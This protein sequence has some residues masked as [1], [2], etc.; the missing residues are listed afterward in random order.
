VWFNP[1]K[2]LTRAGRSGNVNPAGSCVE[3]VRRGAVERDRGIG[4]VSPHK[5]DHPLEQL[6][7]VFVPYAAADDDALPW[8]GTQ[9][10]GDDRLHVVASVEAEEASL[11]AEA[12]L[13]ESSYSHL[14]R[15]GYRLGVPGPG[16]PIRI[17]PD[18]ENSRCQ[19]CR[20][21]LRDPRISSMIGGAVPEP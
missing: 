6:E 10:S 16:N 9:G 21:H 2:V 13:S 8:S 14:D 5:I 12:V 4:S 7:L 20:V 11:N 19:G 17:E 15:V 1:L 18:Y 3:C